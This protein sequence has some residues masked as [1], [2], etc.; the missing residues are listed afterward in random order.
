[1]RLTLAAVALL[2]T[3]GVAMAQTA[4]TPT[5]NPNNTVTPSNQ[6]MTPGTNAPG[7]QT[8]S[9]AV[10]SNPNSTMNSPSAVQTQNTTHRTRRAPVPGA[11]SFTMSQA[12]GRITSDG[13]T[14]VTGLKKDRQGV[15]R[16]TATKDGT[17][18]PVSLDYQGNV[19][20]GQQ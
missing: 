19:T 15:W 4:A 9:A 20:G 3:G 14:N 13:Y 16:A 7:A 12:R 10:N 5:T 18:G 8:P 17:T 6:V 2:A 1:M 11:N